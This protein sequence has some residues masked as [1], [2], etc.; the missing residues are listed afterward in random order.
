[1]NATNAPIQD[2]LRHTLDY[3]NACIHRGDFPAA[4]RALSRALNLSP[5]DPEILSH[6]GRLSL[7]LKDRHSACRDFNDALKLNSRCAPALS[8]LARYHWEQGTIDEAET[9]AKRALAIDAA[10]EDATEVLS[11][12]RG[13]RHESKPDFAAVKQ[14]QTP[15]TPAPPTGAHE[16]A[17]AAV[18]Q[19]I[20][21]GRKF[22]ADVHPPRLTAAHL[23]HSRVVP[24]RRDIL[25][26]LPKGGVCAEIGTQ[27][28]HFSKQIFAEMKPARLHLFDLDFTPFD[29]A[30]FQSA[31]EQGIVQL[32]QGDSSK[33]LATLPDRSFDFIYVDGDHSYDGVVRDLEVAVR[34]IK[35]DGFI[36]CN[37]Y[38]IYSSLEQSKY[39][40][41]RAVNEFCL[42]HDFEIL[43]LG[44]HCWSYHDVALR[45]RSSA[46]HN[47]Q[48]NGVHTNGSN[49][50]NNGHAPSASPAPA[51][52]AQV[53]KLARAVGD[54]WK[55][56]P[57]YDDAEQYME[58]QWQETVWPCIQDAD[59]SC[60]L[61]LAAGH[62]RNSEKLKQHARKIYIVDINQENIDFCRQRFAGDAR[63]E[64]FRNDGC[65][66]DFIPAASLSLVYCFDAMVHFDSDVVRAYLREFQRVLKPGGFGFCHHSNFTKNPG[67]DVH[68]NA[69]WRN[70]MSQAL[71][72]H[73]CA[74][75]GLTVVKSRIVDWSGPESDCVTLFKKP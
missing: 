56:Q 15:L 42:R 1:M 73:Y 50:A 11:A 36:V 6:R 27:T 51:S 62:G 13:Q 31:I 14:T 69:G 32:H 48:S 61:D 64:F 20:D 21:A 34:K 38:T 53:R 29:R 46:Q 25:A 19:F 45:K 55:Q 12:L 40:V 72:A 74:R 22:F 10:D 30:P 44:L 60:V 71:F 33:L 23:A 3:C 75:E 43:Y 9:A 26:Q 54:D 28:G 67:G 66:L 5:R 18:E 63:F 52:E 37:D 7:F 41:Y 47:G 17:R 39:G 57:Y 8:G 68:D 24:H 59:F 16:Q 4:R 2:L 49:G 58:K 35:T 65:S 70:F